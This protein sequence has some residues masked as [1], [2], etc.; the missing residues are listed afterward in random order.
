LAR[1]A[2]LSAAIAALAVLAGCGGSSDEGASQSDPSGIPTPS[3]P[4]AAQIPVLERAASE[5]DCDDAM[6]VVHP[7]V[8]AQP[9]A[10][11]TQRNC[12]D[13]VSRLRGIRGFRASAS[14][15][16]GTAAVVDGEADS[17]P[18][19]LIFALDDGGRFKWIAGSHTRAEADT[20]PPSGVRF[21]PAASAL[22]DALRAGD[23]RAAFRTIASGSRLSYGGLQGFCDKFEDT[24]TASPES[25]GSRLVADPQAA[26]VRLG[27]TRDQAFYGVA[28]DPAGYRTLIVNGAARGSDPTVY[29]VIPAER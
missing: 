16:Y 24:F 21:E 17:G 29:D 13:A 10:G 14:A 18:V 12:G 6:Q 8:L 27:A 2:A 9:E 25:F 26:P 4:I 15:E 23:C 11:A 5:L 28:T 19:S 1:G 20:S 7:A 22:L 3:Q